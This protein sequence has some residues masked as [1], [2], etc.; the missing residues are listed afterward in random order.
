MASSAVAIIATI[1]AL[2]ADDQN[3]GTKVLNFLKRSYLA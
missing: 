1:V 2:L 3:W